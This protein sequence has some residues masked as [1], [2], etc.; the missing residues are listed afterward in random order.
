MVWFVV[1]Y[2][3]EI[4]ADKELENQQTTLQKDMQMAAEIY[5]TTTHDNTTV[6][7]VSISAIEEVV[8]TMLLEYEMLW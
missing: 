1:S 6:S 7:T 8:P 2:L 5:E 3:S 4:E